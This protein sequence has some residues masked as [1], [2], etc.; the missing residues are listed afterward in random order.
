[1]VHI[2]IRA[3][4]NR[5]PIVLSQNPMLFFFS[6]A[7]DIFNRQYNNQKFPCNLPENIKM[8]ISSEVLSIE[9]VVA[10]GKS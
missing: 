9:N 8:C 1:M 2:H 7:I 6:D 3:P 4:K 10:K 5:A